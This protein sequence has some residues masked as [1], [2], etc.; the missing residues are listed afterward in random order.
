M[1]SAVDVIW[2]VLGILGAWLLVAGTLVQALVSL[3]EL[4]REPL[5]QSGLAVDEWLREYPWWRLTRWAE[6]QLLVRELLEESPEEAAAYRRIRHT[7]YGWGLMFLGT[8]FVAL[9]ATLS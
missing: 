5:L 2:S 8:L 3:R 7:V 1:M 9:S 4:L 6:R